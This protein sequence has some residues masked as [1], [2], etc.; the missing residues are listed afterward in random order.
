VGSGSIKA[1]LYDDGTLDTVILIGTWACRFDTDYAAQYRKADGTL[2]S[3]GFAKLR[4]EA[5]DTYWGAIWTMTELGELTHTGRGFAHIA[6]EDAYGLPCSIQESSSFEPHLWVGVDD[7]KPKVLHGDARRLGVPCT[8]TCGWVPYPIPDEV[9]LST[10]MH[11]SIA[12]V[13]GLITHLQH[14][15]DT[16]QLEPSQL[17]DSQ[18][19]SDDET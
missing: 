10:R 13:T 15:L 8:A 16:Q 18:D 3:H 5:W 4:A 9:L 19:G 1:I 14:W 7:A 12:Q 6:F 11:L 17:A 2:T